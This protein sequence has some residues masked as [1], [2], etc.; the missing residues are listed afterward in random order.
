[1]TAVLSENVGYLLLVGIGM[2]L[3]L[4]V[5]LMVK[6][7]TK[8]LG[9]RKTSEWFYTAGRTI[10]TGLIASSIISAWT[11]AATLLQS[12]TVTY[13]FGI[14]G[15]FWY[16]AGASIQ[17]ILFSILAI[18]L[19]RK[20]PTTHTFPELVYARYGEHSHKVF[21]FFGLMTN[22][23]VTA[24]L[25][26]GC[27]AV[28]NSL[29]NVPI[30]YA[31][32]LIPFGIIFYTVFGGLKATLFAEYINT[33]TIFSIILIFVTVFYFVSPDIGGISGMY[34]KL[35][36][37][38]VL[39]PVAGNSMGSYITLA[40]M[41]ALI[42]G[43]INIVGNFGTVFVDQSY[44][45]RAIAS[46]PRASAGGFILGGIAWFAIP[47]ALA[48]TLGLTAVALDIPLTGEQIRLGLVAPTAAVAV[49]GDVGAILILSMVLTAVIAAG[50][51]QL[52]SVSS[53]M[54]YDVYRTY[55]KPSATGRELMRISR[56]TILG[57]GIGMGVLALL[58]F[59]SGLSLQYLYLAMGIMIGSAVAPI[60]L[61]IL[62][63]KTN[64]YS[65]TLGAIIGLIS[66]IVVWLGSSALMIG[67]ISIYSTSHMV[68]L[69]FGNLASLVISLCITLGGSF[70]KPE[71]F[72]FNILKQKI[73]LVDD[74]IR[75]KI[76]NDT[77]EK[78]LVKSLRICKIVGLC[79]SIIIVVVFPASLYIND[80][81][82]S[83]ESF[84]YWVL[85]AIT[86][87]FIAAGITIL[88]PIIEARKSISE[89]LSRA[90]SSNS[91]SH[92]EEHFDDETPLTK[93]LVPVDGSVKSL[94][95]LNHAS[96]LFRT[97]SKL[98]IYLLHVIEWT[99]ENDEN[100]DDEISNQMQ[101]QGRLIL[102]SISIPKNM[103][104]YQRIVKL[105]N[106]AKKIAEVANSLGVQAT[107]M[108]KTG[109]G[110][111]E[112]DIGHVANEVLKTS[113]TPVVL[114]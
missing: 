16:A 62:W 68:P 41:G 61:S 105:G 52:I 85:M 90:S 95:A 25:I 27:A 11:W 2:I 17:V 69:L 48:T 99:D 77:D 60:S 45:Q 65:A 59:Q 102:R 58:M 101:E 32:F 19:K 28:L 112:D 44:W 4:S 76:K 109:L 38:S 53:L 96:Y 92:E 93:I 22:T 83:L 103:N 87:A 1:M 29:T 34:E 36:E 98:R 82:F 114:I 75:T 18:E 10:K 71:N 40:S 84:V 35:S 78:L 8:W 14:A 26:L 89:I 64:R 91:K 94:R 30:F 100:I 66:G 13:E 21:L 49:M 57:F 97:N 108:G 73:L 24:M 23:I 3:T 79:F 7:E 63:K 20:A 111:T 70:V 5:V 12:S 55:L 51:S 110:N 88:I 43:V 113:K 31:V 33:A 54:T 86:W 37:A 56:F 6:A 9:T 47:F 46:R 104:D 67:E 39:K 74:K 72:D 80:Y 15:S 81:V 42:F 50:S 107:V 106:P